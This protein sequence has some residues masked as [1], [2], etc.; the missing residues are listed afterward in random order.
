MDT[1]AWPAHRCSKVSGLAVF[2]SL[3]STRINFCVQ[4]ISVNLVTLRYTACT[5]A[6]T[7]LLPFADNELKTVKFFKYETSRISK[8]AADWLAINI[9]H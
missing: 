6:K 1:F 7:S 9:I 4:F 2:M 3:V 8:A 5:F